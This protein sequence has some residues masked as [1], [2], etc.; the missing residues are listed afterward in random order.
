MTMEGRKIVPDALTSL[1]ERMKTGC[2]CFDEGKCSHGEII[3]SAISQMSTFNG[4]DCD[5]DCFL[6]ACSLF[7]KKVLFIHNST[8]V[9]ACLLFSSN[10]A[11]AERKCS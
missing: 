7:L 4:G 3:I 8:Q 9:W 5:P 2:L 6:M 11:S 10:K 1:H